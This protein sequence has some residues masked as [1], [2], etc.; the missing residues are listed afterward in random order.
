MVKD[1][2]L[3]AKKAFQ[4]YKQRKKEIIDNNLALPG[5]K[6]QRAYYILTQCLLSLITWFSGES[7]GYLNEKEVAIPEGRTVLFANTHKFKPDIEKITLSINKPSVMI[8]SDFVN[9][10]KTIS[11]WYFGTRP[12]I[13]VDPYSKEDKDYTYR[14][15]V[16]YLKEGR[17]C[18]I[19]PEA[20]WNLSENRIVLGTFL[21][22]VR[23]ALESNSV[24][25]CTAIE[26]YGKKYVINRKGFF[27]PSVILQEYTDLTFDKLCE[28]NKP[29][30][31]RILI[32]CN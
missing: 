30:A 9:S 19:F 17:A 20:V 18:M 29:L 26:R 2:T 25:V 13:F 27:D 12:T 6:K 32:R 22:T 4:Q 21:G 24:I 10:Y 1:K 8:A 14:M 16:R 7:I 5:L 28:D 31:K 11:G 23:A 15:M 3:R